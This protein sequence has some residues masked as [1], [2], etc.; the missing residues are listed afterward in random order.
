M[1]YLN[2]KNYVEVGIKRYIIQLTENIT[3]R[4]SK[5]PKSLRNQNEVKLRPNFEKIKRFS[6]FKKLGWKLKDILKSKKKTKTE[7]NLPSSPNCKQNN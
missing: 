4:E 1:K 6:K 3:L 2:C 5:H 7:N